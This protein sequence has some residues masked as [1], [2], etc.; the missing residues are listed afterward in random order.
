ASSTRE[1][2][3]RPRSISCDR[4]PASVSFGA[5]GTMDSFRIWLRVLVCLALASFGT[6]CGAL[7]AAT[8]PKVSWAMSDPAPMTVVVR[9]A[10]AAEATGKNVERLLLT[11]PIDEQGAW[12]GKTAP[13]KDEAQKKAD[14]IAARDEYALTGA[15]VIPAEVWSTTLAG[16]ASAPPTLTAAEVPKPDAAPK[17]DKRTNRTAKKKEAPPPPPPP[18]APPKYASLLAAVDP[19]LGDKANAVLAKRHEIG[20]IEAKIAT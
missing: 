20:E 19:A 1:V 17:T 7:S 3:A 16:V 9:R 4:G 8:N 12:I 14:E 15:R 11:T 10:D 18:P 13:E 2:Y 6:G 5:G